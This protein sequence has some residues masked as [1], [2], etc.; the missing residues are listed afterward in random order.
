MEEKQ[1][2]IEGKRLHPVLAE[3]NHSH[4]DLLDAMVKRGTI[5][6]LILLLAYA[7]PLFTF[8][9]RLKTSQDPKTR[10]LCLAGMTI[11]LAYLGFG[12]TQAFLPHNSG[13]MVYVY[14]SCLIWAATEGMPTPP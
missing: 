4:N 11:P 10:A 14:L 5:G 2:A 13:L 12:L 7:T 9:Q 6:L 3:F 8:Y 1:R